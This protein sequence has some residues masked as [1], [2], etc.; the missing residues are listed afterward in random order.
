M[1]PFRTLIVEDFE[2]YRCLLRAILQQNTRCEVI[3]EASDGLQAVWQAEELQPDL[4]L[5]DIGCPH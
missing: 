5:L 1:A 3:G 4:I 2:D